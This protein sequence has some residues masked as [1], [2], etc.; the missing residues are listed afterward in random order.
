MRTVIFSLA[1]ALATAPTAKANFLIFTSQTEFQSIAPGLPRQDFSSAD[2]TAGSFA[3]VDGPLDSSSDNG[4]FDRGDII[5][6]LEIS[7]DGSTP[8]GNRL[9]VAGVGTVGNTAKAIYTNGSNS[10]MNLHLNGPSAVGLK[11]IG[12]T[13]GGPSRRFTVSIETSIGSRA[14]DTGF[15]PT[16]GDGA[17]LGLIGQSGETISRIRF[18]SGPGANEGITHIEFGAITSVPEPSS[19][20]SIAGLCFLLVGRRVRS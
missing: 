19:L 14:F 18:Q 17:F 13:N 11:L 7:A 3:F 8:L 5:P 9:Y 16:T 12:F 15:I 6:G 20:L 1:V 4:V 10:T 2:V